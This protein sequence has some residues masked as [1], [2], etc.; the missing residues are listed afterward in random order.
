MQELFRHNALERDV[1]LHCFPMHFI[2]ESDELPREE[3]LGRRDK[4]DDDEAPTLPFFTK[5]HL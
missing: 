3:S 2:I 4:P 1:L 5:P